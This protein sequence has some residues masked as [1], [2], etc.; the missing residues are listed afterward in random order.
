MRFT[1]DYVNAFCTFK[2]SRQTFSGY[3]GF[4]NDS[5]V[6]LTS[7]NQYIDADFISGVVTFLGRKGLQVFRAD[8]VVTGEKHDILTFSNMQR[9]T[10]TE[11]RKDFRVTAELP[12]LVTAY[13]EPRIG[14]DA[15]IKDISVR[16]ASIWV[17]K[18][19]DTDDTVD[20]Q[21]VLDE[22]DN[23]LHRCQCN[24]V[25]VISKSNIGVCRYGCEFVD[26]PQSSCEAIRTLINKKRAEKIKRDMFKN[27]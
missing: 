16:G 17:H 10:D 12:A 25:R 21:F 3:V 24:I 18:L 13:N 4:V 27:Y 14:Y 20:V 7:I 19:F 11:R 15:T 9:I 5:A 26:L 23:S 6:I 22:L 1:T 8:A 2:T